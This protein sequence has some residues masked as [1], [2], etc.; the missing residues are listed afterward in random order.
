MSLSPPATRPTAVDVRVGRPTPCIK[1]VGRLCECSACDA[2]PFS[3]LLARKLFNG[4]DVRSLI[5]CYA[6]CKQHGENNREAI[7]MQHACL[8]HLARMHAAGFTDTLIILHGGIVTEDLGLVVARLWHIENLCKPIDVKTFAAMRGMRYLMTD[9]SGTFHQTTNRMTRRAKKWLRL[10]SLHGDP[11]ATVVLAEN[12]GVEKNMAILEF[13]S[14]DYHNPNPKAALLCAHEHAKHGRHKKAFQAAR[15]A[16]L[17]EN[18]ETGKTID[19]A[20]AMEARERCLSAITAM[21]NGETHVERFKGIDELFRAIDGERAAAAA[22]ALELAVPR[23]TPAARLCDAVVTNAEKEHPCLPMAGDLAIICGSPPV[24]YHTHRALISAAST[25][26]E[27]AVAQTTGDTLVLA[28]TGFASCMPRILRHI[29]TPDRTRFDD[30]TDALHVAEGANYYGLDDL[31]EESLKFV[32]R[33][34]CIKT[35]LRVWA[36]GQKLGRGNRHGEELMRLSHRQ[37]M[38]NLADAT[39]VPELAALP[40]TALLALLTE[41]GGHSNSNDDA[42]IE[43]LLRWAQVSRCS[44]M[45]AGEL[46]SCGTV[47]L[48]QLTADG[49]RFATCHPV[50]KPHASLVTILARGFAGTPSRRRPATDLLQ[51][52]PVRRRNND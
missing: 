5:K 45:K 25:F 48:C 2:G 18:A 44:P 15:R 24:T 10:A 40:E 7:R 17:C 47:D 51:S 35:S 11:D 37:L 46:L 43:C 33:A 4:P 21:T 20:L 52:T 38:Y 50:V 12:A 36:T 42:K 9:D 27:N 19:G 34:I 41:M 1:G 28:D 6:H 14:M 8:I 16:I 29:Y 31:C 13:L 26:F 22:L 3:E 30:I 39:A 32:E 49:F 23:K